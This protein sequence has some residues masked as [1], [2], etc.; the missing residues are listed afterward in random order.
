MKKNP[1][2]KRMS[3]LAMLV[4]MASAVHYLES[5]L[6]PIL[7]S[8]PGAKLGLAN[9]F[10]LAALVRFGYGAGITV[11]VLRCLVG[12]LIGGSV[13]ALLYALAGGILSYCAMAVFFAALKTRFSL[14]GISMIG[15][16]CHN[17]GQMFMASFV[18]GNA[19]VWAYFPYLA[20]LSVPTGLFTGTVTH[21]SLK[22]LDRAGVKL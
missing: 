22:A 21:F 16:L 6:P 10:T 12:T 4:A 5:L 18:L 14:S 7:P 19:Y 15:A 13:T 1:N 2:I 9:I 11:T 17:V 3:Y 20:L 8:L